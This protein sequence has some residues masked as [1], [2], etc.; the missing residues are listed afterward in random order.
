[1]PSSYTRIGLQPANTSRVPFF[2]QFVFGLVAVAYP[3]LSILGDPNRTPGVL[4]YLDW[5]FLGLAV[6]F[7][8][9]I[10]VQNLP[11]FGTQ[12][13]LEITPDYLVHKSGLFAPKQPFAAKEMRALDLEPNQLLLRLH[14]GTSY[15]LNL[16][17][18]RGRQRRQNLRGMLSNFAQR[19]GLE[20]RER[21]ASE[22]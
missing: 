12:T 9:Y 2:G 21:S 16:R 22:L 6:V 15:A 1:M 4:R 8:L 5:M 19:N 17:Q 20:L 14:D 10:S 18:V 3:L 13:Y 7:L 11:L